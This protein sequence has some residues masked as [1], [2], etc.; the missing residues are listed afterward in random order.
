MPKGKK[1]HGGGAADCLGPTCDWTLGKNGFQCIDG[2][3]GC[4]TPH[5]CEADESSFHDKD[6]EDATKKLNRILAKIPA[7]PKGLKLSFCETNMGTLLA[8]VQH[9]GKAGSGKTVTRNDDDATVAKALKLKAG[10]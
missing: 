4:S 8:W 6:L 2:T 10:K 5:F 9:G 7:P 3:G 1:D